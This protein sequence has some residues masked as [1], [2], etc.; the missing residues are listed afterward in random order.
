MYKINMINTKPKLTSSNGSKIKMHKPVP[1]NPRIATSRVKH[2]GYKIRPVEQN[3]DIIPMSFL[4]F[5]IENLKQEFSRKRYGFLND[6]YENVI[7]SDDAYKIRKLRKSLK[8]L[9]LNDKNIWKREQ[10]R[11]HI[12]CPR[13][14][15]MIYYSLCFILDLSLIHI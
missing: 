5:C 7:D 8:D 15:L 6:P 10:M 3:S 11:D 13:V 1:I 2:Y 9:K 14:L 4:D 12:E